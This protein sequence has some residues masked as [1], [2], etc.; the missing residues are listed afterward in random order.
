MMRVASHGR[1]TCVLALADRNVPQL[2]SSQSD[3]NVSRSSTN[4]EGL[5]WPRSPVSHLDCARSQACLWVSAHEARQPWPPQFT[6][7]HTHT[8][9][10]CYVMLNCSFS[11][12]TYFS[13]EQTDLSWVDSRAGCGL[14][15]LTQKCKR[16]QQIPLMLFSPP[17]KMTSLIL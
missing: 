17:S 14:H 8:R 6:H 12:N 3:N 11:L 9:K 2:L 4:D 16:N 1:Q 15:L 10:C 7:T 13:C 5:W